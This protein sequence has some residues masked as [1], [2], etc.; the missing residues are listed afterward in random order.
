MNFYKLNQLMQIE[1]QQKLVGRTFFV[2]LDETLIVSVSESYEELLKKLDEYKNSESKLK[3]RMLEKYTPE[4]IN[5][6]KNGYYLEMPGRN[7]TVIPR[8]HLHEFINSLSAKGDVHILTSSHSSYAN[9]I[10]SAFD[11]PV[12]SVLSTGDYRQDQ[13]AIIAKEL[14]ITDH[15]LVLFDDLPDNTIGIDMKLKMLGPNSRNIKVDPWTKSVL[16]LDDTGLLDSL[17]QSI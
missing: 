15:E 9:Q 1:E 7:F 17:S 12:K 6:Y 8:P 14:G 5:L 4:V 10:V 13:N 2:D 16:S 3:K 11:I